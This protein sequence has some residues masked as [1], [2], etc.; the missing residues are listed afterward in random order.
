MAGDALEAALPREMYVDPQTWLAERERA[1]FG[2][3]FCVGRTSDLGLD[4]DYKSDAPT[5]KGPIDNVRRQAPTRASLEPV[6]I[7]PMHP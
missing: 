6:N 2:Q 1:L 3:W 7:T 4:A 5:S